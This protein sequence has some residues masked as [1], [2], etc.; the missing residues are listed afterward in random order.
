MKKK[1]FIWCI[2]VKKDEA[3]NNQPSIINKYLKIYGR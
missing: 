3:K 2:K 1:T